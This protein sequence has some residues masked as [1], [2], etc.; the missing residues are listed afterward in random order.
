MFPLN[1]P[2]RPSVVSRFVIAVWLAVASAT[3]FAFLSALLFSHLDFINH[4]LTHSIAIAA[5]LIG[6]IAGIAAF[7]Q[8]TFL[9]SK[10]TYFRPL[11]QHHH[12]PWTWMMW[13]FFG[14]FAFRSFCWLVYY[15]G[16]LIKI[17]SPN[18]RADLILH[19]LHARYFAS[20]VRWWPDNPIITGSA[21]RYYPGIDL[22]QSLLLLVK[23]EH[24]TAFIWTGL[25]GCFAIAFLLQRWGGAFAIAGFL[26]NGG[27][28]GFK[29]FNESLSTID[30]Y[31]WD[32]AWKSLPLAILV[33]QRGFLFALPVGLLLLIHW[34]RQFFA[35]PHLRAPLLPFW[36]ELLFYIS[37][38][39]FQLFSFLFVSLLLGWWFLIRFR[40]REIRNHLLKLVGLAFIPVTLE[41]ALM[42][43]GFKS[44]GSGHFFWIQLGWMQGK[45]SFLHF[46]LINFGLMLPL[47]ATFWIW[48]CYQSFK[49]TKAEITTT[50][51]AFV[52]PSGIIFLICCVVMLAPWE[53]DNTKLM[54]WCYLTMLPF[55]YLCWIQKLPTILRWIC[56]LL[57]FFSGAISLAGGINLKHQESGGHPLGQR[58][59]VD[60]TAYALKNIPP[61]ARFASA[62]TYNH[63]LFFDGRKVALGY[64]GT[65]HSYGYDY[66]P[67]EAALQHL[68]LGTSDWKQCAAQLGIRYIYWSHFEEKEY[69]NS[70]KP[71]QT[72]LAPNGKHYRIVTQSQYATVYDLQTMEGSVD[73]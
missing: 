73:N 2:R 53:W 22:F 30:D 18:N 64:P 9:Q 8:T 29:I 15:D 50:A 67:I 40:D 26:F 58:D 28:A 3:V 72:E 34:R 25:F 54:M 65:V 10:I 62:P 27:L 16:N 21:L 41:V 31:Q 44:A 24:W 19:T 63:P 13:F 49:K 39:L 20:G 12:S 61:T 57:L 38:P 32:L 45:D 7:I 69:P 17:L 42:T 48:L 55:L 36:V 11:P 56:C 71:W 68:M 46:W 51:A 47:A 14:I 52:I 66:K 70:K 43:N 35:L 60:W 5:L 33:T 59:Q 1:T 6:A 37:L 23:A 4:G